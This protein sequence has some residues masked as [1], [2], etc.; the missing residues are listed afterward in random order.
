MFLFVLFAVLVGVGSFY[1]Y[2]NDYDENHY[3]VQCVLHWSVAIVLAVDF[4]KMVFLAEGEHVHTTF[5]H[6]V[7]LLLG[8]EAFFVFYTLFISLPG[9]GFFNNAIDKAGYHRVNILRYYRD[10]EWDP[11]IGP[12]SDFARECEGSECEEQAHIVHLEL[13]TDSTELQTLLQPS[14][15]EP[16]FATEVS[17]SSSQVGVTQVTVEVVGMT[18]TVDIRLETRAEAKA[19]AVRMRGS[20]SLTTPTS[21]TNLLKTAAPSATFQVTAAPTIVVV[22][23]TISEKEKFPSPSKEKEQHH[24]AVNRAWLVFHACTLL[25]TGILFLLNANL[26]A[27]SEYFLRK[28]RIHYASNIMPRSISGANVPPLKIF[29]VVMAILCLVCGSLSAYRFTQTNQG[30]EK[31][32]GGEG[33]YAAAIG[34]F[35]VAFLVYC[36]Y[37]IKVYYKKN[38]YTSTWMANLNRIWEHNVDYNNAYRDRLRGLDL[39]ATHKLQY[40]KN[41]S[42]ELAQQYSWLALG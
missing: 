33:S 15:L 28:Y 26:R 18:V 31:G 10:F 9:F 20:K 17:D 36:A 38:V 21:L 4:A 5:V 24:R 30:V 29:P 27:F 14:M 22:D 2:G 7:L 35:F 8:I 13:V 1:L 16:R 23:E 25:L 41:L 6:I 42:P 39:T 40:K 34:V 32:Y 12:V 19:L 3:E 11:I 37:F